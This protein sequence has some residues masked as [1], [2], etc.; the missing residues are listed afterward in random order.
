[1]EI[2]L[3]KLATTKICSIN[4]FLTIGARTPCQPFESKHIQHE[5]STHKF[6]W[7]PA[8][9]P[10][11]NQIKKTKSLWT[12]NIKVLCLVL[13]LFFQQNKIPPRIIR[14]LWNRRSSVLMRIHASCWSF[15]VI[16]DN[17]YL[18]KSIIHEAITL[19]STI[20]CKIKSEQNKKGEC[21]GWPISK[22]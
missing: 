21:N 4:L 10:M 5:W 14:L 3:Y 2:H 19:C 22:Q 17:L 9:R 6:S 13:I 20:P 15:K 12:K 1:M 16:R 18:P 8:M 7:S 11:L